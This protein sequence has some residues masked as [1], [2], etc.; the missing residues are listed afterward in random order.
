MDERDETVDLLFE[1][2]DTG[3][4]IS[5]EHQAIIFDAFEQAQS[6]T[7]RVYG[8]TGLGLSISKRLA[9][10]MGGDAGVISAPGQGSTFWF[11]V[12]L[13]RGTVLQQ[14]A[15][16]EGSALISGGA[17]ILLVED[18]DINQE[19]ARELLESVGLKVDIA[20]H[21]GEALEKLRTG[22]YGLVLMDM[23]M[24][25]MDGLEATRKIRAMDRY[26]D[27]PIL[28]MTANAFS[29]DRQRCL[30]AGMNGYVA[31]P[32]EARLLYAALAR[33]LPGNVNP[34]YPPL[35]KGGRGDFTNA[36]DTAVHNGRVSE[37]GVR[38]YPEHREVNVGCPPWPLGSG[39]PCRNDEQKP[40]STASGGSP[41]VSATRQID[42]VAG[43]KYFSGKLSAY[44]R[45]LVKF[46]DQHGADAA[47]LQAALAAG[48]RA[49][50]ERIAHSL[51]GLAAM[52]G[53]QGVRQLAADLEHKIRGGADERELA[54]T[55]TALNEMLVE[56][57]MEIRAIGIDVK[58]TPRVDANPAQVRELLAKLETQLEQD[59]M[60]ACGI[61][62]EL[63]PLLA[64]SP[65]DK[66][67]AL[68][69]QIE[70][71]DFPQALTSLRTIMAEQGG[72]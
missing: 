45:V 27:L 54:G 34:P 17:H 15:V 24:P 8:G 48:D 35:K 9:R 5:Q 56:V 59:D 57:C 44:Q 40:A 32:V 53:V 11:T 72:V 19:V 41:E 1:V 49:T 10:L 2:E 12:R 21:G 43:L 4:G 25:V 33:W 67:S 47:S 50:A 60:N 55:I 51:K 23:Q 66:L 6:S 31:K 28:A 14:W 71:F 29:E 62:R 46:S 52:L 64:S 63:R 68:G 13:K 65:D 42:T 36:V 37:A 26:K 18:N 16:V 58:G 61:W 20:N 3:I 38:R 30:E 69:R 22:S 7:T 70:G 39:N